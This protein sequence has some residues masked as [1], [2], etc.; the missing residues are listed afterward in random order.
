MLAVNC[1]I[2]FVCG[3][4]LTRLAAPFVCGVPLTRLAAR[5]ELTLYALC[6]RCHPE[7]ST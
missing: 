6:E 3:V 5:L 7:I 2:P 1:H 4:P